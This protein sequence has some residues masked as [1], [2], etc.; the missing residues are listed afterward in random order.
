MDAWSVWTNLATLVVV[1]GAVSLVLM[2]VAATADGA[3]STPMARRGI[4][5]GL[6]VVGVLA[7][8]TAGIVVAVVDVADPRWWLGPLSWGVWIAGEVV[9]FLLMTLL[10]AVDRR[11]VRS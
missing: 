9:T 7:S 3:P 11:L 1:G 2:L 4:P 6:G 5:Q 10:F 8:L